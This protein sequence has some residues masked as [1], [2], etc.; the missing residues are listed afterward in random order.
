MKKIFSIFFFTSFGILL[1]FQNSE[2]LIEKLLEIRQNYIIEKSDFETSFIFSKE[3]YLTI[4]SAR[5]IIVADK[6]YDIKKVI[7]LENKVKL[8]VIEDKNESLF[9]FISHSLKKENSKKNKAKIKRNIILALLTEPEIERR[10]IL[11]DGILTSFYKEQKN[12]KKIISLLLKPPI[13][14]TKK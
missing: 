7:L 10:I 9:K 8:V 13:I 12:P 11:I 2:P 6:Y 5:E 1:F 14:L 3:S 4:K